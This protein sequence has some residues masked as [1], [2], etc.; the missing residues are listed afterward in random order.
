LPVF[1]A[2]NVTFS[3][4]LQADAEFKR[5]DLRAYVMLQSVQNKRKT[6][7]HRNM[8]H[9][10]I[11]KEIVTREGAKKSGQSVNFLTF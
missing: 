9:R 3:W 2:R 6:D 11:E 1:E 4:N 8:D 5:S 10:Q 7:C